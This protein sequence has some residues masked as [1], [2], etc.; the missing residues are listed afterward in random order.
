MAPSEA[1]LD[2][3]AWTIDADRGA[4]I[5]ERYG[6]LV[7]PVGV[8]PTTNGLKGHCSTIELQTRASGRGK[9]AFQ[10]SA[11]EGIVSRSDTDP[12]ANFPKKRL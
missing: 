11:S 3:L 9:L 6:A 12:L 5:A 1:Q 4:N 2:K 10:R 8:E 7:G